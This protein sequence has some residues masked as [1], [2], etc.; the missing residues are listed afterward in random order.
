MVLSCHYFG[1]ILII[2]DV[3]KYVNRFYTFIFILVLETSIVFVI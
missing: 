2:G 3:Y 1:V